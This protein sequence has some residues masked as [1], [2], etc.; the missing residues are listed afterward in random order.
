MKLFHSIFGSREILG[1]FALSPMNIRLDPADASA[2]RMVFQ[3]LATAGGQQATL[4]PVTIA[5][6]DL[7]PPEDLVTA[8]EGYL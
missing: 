6:R 3:E 8:A 1:H 4:L 5:M 7:L 2:R